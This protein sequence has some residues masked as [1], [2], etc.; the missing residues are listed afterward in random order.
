MN[1]I[2]LH[3]DNLKSADSLK[4]FEFN[5]NSSMSSTYK[6]VNFYIILTLHK[7]VQAKTAVSGDE[8]VRRQPI[9][10]N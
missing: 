1:S 8:C 4:Y 9:Q 5:S 7:C 6:L 2:N 3:E 10:N